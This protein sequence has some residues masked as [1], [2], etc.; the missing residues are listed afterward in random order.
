MVS[1]ARSDDRFLIV[2]LLL[3]NSIS[4]DCILIVV[5]VLVVLVVDADVAVVD[6][7]QSNVDGRQFSSFSPPGET[8][9]P[10]L[11]GMSQPDQEGSPN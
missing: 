2:F 4:C 10:T 9:L 3:I 7:N 8:S 6:A 5:D 1:D 11:I